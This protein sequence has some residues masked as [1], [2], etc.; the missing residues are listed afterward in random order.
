MN[1][2]LEALKNALVCLCLVVVLFTSCRR[3]KSTTALLAEIGRLQ[4]VVQEVVS[5][6]GAS[7]TP[8]VKDDIPTGAH[9]IPTNAEG[10]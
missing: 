10:L 9:D 5:P 3:D 2:K 4:M 6:T 7:D 1:E 8:T